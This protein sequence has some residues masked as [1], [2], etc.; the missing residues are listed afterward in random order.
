[1]TYLTIYNISENTA[2]RKRITACAA[3]EGIEFPDQ[4]TSSKAIYWA[5]LPGW[6]DAWE[7]ALALDPNSDPGENEA[8]ITDLMILSGVQTLNV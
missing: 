5:S 4:W 8:A 2:M 6:A 1:M 3:Q 7:Y